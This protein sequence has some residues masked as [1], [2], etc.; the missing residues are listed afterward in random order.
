MGISMVAPGSLLAIKG[1]SWVDG[2]MQQFDPYF[3]KFGGEE[4]VLIVEQHSLDVGSQLQRSI[5]GLGWQLLRP[6]R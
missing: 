2:N 4:G 5:R 6:Y 3:L 1:T